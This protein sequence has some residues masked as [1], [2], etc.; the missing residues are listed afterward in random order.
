[1][2]RLLI[3]VFGLA[4]CASSA[5]AYY[6]FYHYTTRNAPYN[7]VPEKFD[8]TA[9]PNKT[10]TFLI[11]DTSAAA[12]S[13]SSLY[14]SALSAIRQA[15][16]V[17]NAIDS[18][19]VRVAFGGIATSAT[20]QNT[21]G[22]DIVFDEMDPF[23]LGLT[24]TNA[25]NSVAF[26]SSGAFVPLQRP[27][28][29]LN[30]N[31][32]VWT[33]P[34]FT[35][36]FFL[37]VAHEMGHALGLQHTFTSSL[38][39]TEAA[40]RAT[41]LY[42]PLTADDI[43][44]I[45][46]LYPRGN[47]SQATGSIAGRITFSNGQGVHLASVVA[48]RPTGPALSALT[49]PD[50]RFR[51]DGIPPN[52]Y[53]LYVHPLPPPPRA[54]AAPGDLTLPVGPDG[55][56]VQAAGPFQTLFYQGGQGTRDYTQAQTL[57]VSPGALLDNINLTMNQT[58]SY[59]I[60]SVTTYTYFNNT[61][62]WPGYLNGGGT[63]VAF[64]TG[65]TSNGAP[66]PGLSVSFLGGAPALADAV[67]AYSG[68]YLALDLQATPATTG[69]RHVVF[70]LP[71]DIYVLPSGLNLVQNSPPQIASVTPG[72]ES[73][74]SRS[75]AVAGSTLSSSTLF[76]L[77]GIPAPLLRFDGQGRA[78]VSPAPGLGGLRSVVT[79]FNPDGQNSMFVQSTFPI[80]Y[81]FD[82]GDPGTASF[83]PSS[84]PAGT[85]S[86]VEITGSNSNFVD[87]VTMVGAGSSDVQVRRSWVVAPNK[88]W[89]NIYVAPSAA[90]TASLASVIN[91]FQVISQPF[92]I[93]TQGFNG[94]TPSLSSQLVNATPNQTGILPGYLVI[95][96]GSN[97]TNPAITVSGQSA[98]ILNSTPNQV[99]FQI[100][101]G[102]PAGP[103]VLRFSNGVDTAAVVISID[104][105]Q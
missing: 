40:G 49:D 35:E 32:S 3:T 62:V 94:R 76:Y 59:T 84:L 87:G 79:A 29:H 55:Q 7:P 75:L 68:T 28:V 82:T 104:A 92:G 38:M 97:L 57:T 69:P 90:V 86:W 2:R 65:L 13:Q 46:Y 78:I 34:S 81:T 22:V 39:S 30:P 50:G 70:S 17:W 4:L 89:A 45:S 96:S 12:I 9:L 67:R 24:S 33:K 41:S 56:P 64:G 88:I 21:P 63:L 99:T 48:I 66:T 61:A 27:L 25:K 101:F 26:G 23:L 53:L 83:S 8:L 85:E 16:S 19:D 20:P 73:N 6:H 42:A 51:I 11:S 95:L 74:G 98:T 15:A 5:G 100:P 36:E 102:L 60:P 80:T 93:Q 72:F 91:G 103:A 52:Q 37:T 18:S 105:G 44:G 31:L 47:F 54:G 14:P 10:V 43:A 58:A 71:S 1:M 77:D